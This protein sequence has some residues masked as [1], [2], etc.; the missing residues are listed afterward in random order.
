MVKKAEK[1][2]GKIAENPRKEG[3]RKGKEPQLLPPKCGPTNHTTP[4]NQVAAWK[5]STMKEEEI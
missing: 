1:S 2:K 4:P 5:A 3:F